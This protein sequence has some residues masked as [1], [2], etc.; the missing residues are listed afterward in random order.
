MAASGEGHKDA[1]V[2]VLGMLA[3]AT[4]FVLQF[5]RLEPL[6]HALAD[7]GKIT[8]PEATSTSP[9]PPGWRL[10]LSWSRSHLPSFPDVPVRSQTDICGLPAATPR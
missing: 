2:G 4:A 9:W 10:W 8:K 1:M 7:W 3:G 6:I 5:P